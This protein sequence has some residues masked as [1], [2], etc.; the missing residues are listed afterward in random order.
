MKQFFFFVAIT[1]SASSLFGQLQYT[2]FEKICLEEET[3]S[4]L[5]IKYIDDMILAKT[6]YP[7]SIIAIDAKTGQQLW[8]KSHKIGYGI[9]SYGADVIVSKNINT[10]DDATKR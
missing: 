6:D 2:S 8:S 4:L 3:T 1:L 9:H 5:N 10:Y 7:G